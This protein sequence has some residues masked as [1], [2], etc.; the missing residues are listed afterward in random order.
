[1]LQINNLTKIYKTQGQT[2]YALNNVSLLLPSSGMVFLL[3]KSGSGKSTMLNVVGGLDTYDSGEIIIK[4]RSSTTFTQKDFDSY[5]NT[6]VGFVFQEYNVLDDFTVGKNIALALELQ[7]KQASTEAVEELLTKVGIQGFA[8]RKPNQLSGGQRQRVAIARALIKDPEIILADEPTGA[9]DSATSHSVFQTLKYLSQTRLVVVVSH[10]REFAELYGDRIIEMADGRIIADV[11]KRKAPIQQVSD[12]VTIS[13]RTAFVAAGHKLD[14]N[15]INVLSQLLQNNTSGIV[16]SLDD[17]VNANFKQFAKMDA[18]GSREFFN[19]TQP[20]DILVDKTQSVNLIRSRFKFWD[21]FKMGAS[22]LKLK[23]VRLAFTIFLAMVALT[24][25]GIADTAAAFNAPVSMLRSKNVTGERLLGIGKYQNIEEDWGTWREAV[26]MREADI[27]YLQNRFSHH[28]FITSR[29]HRFNVPYHQNFNFSWNYHRTQTYSAFYLTESEMQAFGLT[30]MHGSLPQGDTEVAITDFQFENFRKLGFD[31]GQSNHLNQ[32][33]IANINIPG[34]IFGRELFC[35][36]SGLRVEIVG[37]INTNFDFDM[38]EPLSRPNVNFDMNLWM[39][40]DTF[41]ATLLYGFSNSLFFHHDNTYIND[42]LMGR[43]HAHN[44]G[45]VVLPQGNMSRPPVSEL[46]RATSLNETYVVRFDE[47]RAEQQNDIIID[48]NS[49]AIASG[50]WLSFHYLQYYN[51]VQLVVTKPYEFGWWSVQ[52][53]THHSTMAEFAYYLKNAIRFLYS[54][55]AIYTSGHIHVW[56]A[57]FVNIPLNIVGVYLPMLALDIQLLDSFNQTAHNTAIYLSDSFINAN[58]RLTYIFNPPPY[59]AALTML[60]GNNARD[61]ELMRFIAQFRDTD[62]FRI[63]NQFSTFYENFTQQASYIAFAFLIIGIIFAV[64]AALMI[65]SFIS[66][67]ITYK[68]REIG[69]LRAL[70]ARRVDIYKIFFNEALI[71][72]GINWVLACIATAVAIFIMNHFIGGALGVV[73]LL[74]G[75]RQIALLL[76]IS[77]LIAAV[78]SFLPT[79]RISRLKPIDAIQNRK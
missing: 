17:D 32:P 50:Y 1:M 66:M 55:N 71:I 16:I 24:F 14:T 36:S 30:L 65:S 69:I 8:N 73:L 2:V 49:L 9:L 5:R 67:T 19:H 41:A 40:S 59:L 79:R 46:A 54:E 45:D 42:R 60:T 3:G 70:G 10:D 43:I 53:V 56:Q 7:G 47:G 39:L 27:A 25:F 4:G 48:W 77:L 15:E 33:I 37:I 76:G 18:S 72:N 21:S 58:A 74:F 68:K 64:F 31:T 44:I 26:G 34:D 38:F 11:T 62:E 61:M 52:T 20:L 12:A 28:N 29:P 13:G 35:H 51:L 57:P 63:R 75:I 78:A 6:Y 23:K 22:G